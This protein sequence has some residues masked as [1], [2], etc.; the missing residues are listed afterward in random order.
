[1]TH[2]YQDHYFHRAKKEHF[3][4]RAVY[5]LEEIQLRYK[6]LKPGYR[7]LDL[8]AFPGS[9]LQFCSN[10]VGP[11]GLVLGVDLKQ[12]T[13]TF[14]PHVV[15]LQ[16]DV[17]APGF[18]EELVDRFAPFEVVLSDMAPATSGIRVADSARSALLVEQA[19]Q[20]ARLTLKPNGHFL[21]KIFQGTDFHD[22]LPEVKKAFHQVKVVKPAASRKQSK[23]VYILA[24]SFKK[25]DE[26]G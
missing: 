21:A 9:W 26:G 10:L 8:G 2:A 16:R 5:K 22:L 17:M 6:L 19:L 24:L 25:T 1:M 18:L 13:H 4:A 15:F 14:P 7:V 23:E 20:V 12:I 3:L 11:R